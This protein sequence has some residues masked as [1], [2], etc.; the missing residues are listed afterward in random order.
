MCKDDSLFYLTV[1][2]NHKVG[3]YWYKR[4]PV[5]IHR[6]DGIMKTVASNGKLN[7]KKTQPFC[8]KD[9]NRLWCS[10]LATRAFRAWSITRDRLLSRRSTCLIC[11]A[12][13]IH[14]HL[15]QSCS[16]LLQCLFSHHL[17]SQQLVTKEQMNIAVSSSNQGLFTNG[18]CSNC[19]FNLN[20]W[21]KPKRPRVIYSDSKDRLLYTYYIRTVIVTM[22]SWILLSVQ[23]MAKLRFICTKIDS[24]PANHTSSWMQSLLPWAPFRALGVGLQSFS[25]FRSALLKIA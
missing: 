25:S 20:F 17:F 12:T 18:S 22:C 24:S 14:H 2:H 15:L 8:Q 6:I 10:L 21:Q 4:Q 16:Q 23:I 5:G 13:T 9:T 11:W 3:S 1:N 19:T 7:G